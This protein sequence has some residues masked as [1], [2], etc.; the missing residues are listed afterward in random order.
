MVVKLTS[1]AQ[2]RGLHAGTLIQTLVARAGG[3][4]GGRPDIAQAGVKN[5]DHIKLC[6]DAIP[7]I[8]ESSE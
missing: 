6:L 1:D 5:P 4:G 2:K 3:S 8:L 7:E